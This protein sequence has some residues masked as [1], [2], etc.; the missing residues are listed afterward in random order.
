MGDERLQAEVCE[1]LVE[2][3]FGAEHEMARHPEVSGEEA[4]EHLFAVEVVPHAGLL[5]NGVAQKLED[6]SSFS[7]DGHAPQQAG[8]GQHIHGQY[9]DIVVGVSQM[10]VEQPPHCLVGNG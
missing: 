6:G 8:E 2:F 4:V 5:G 9:P 7:V 3:R 1:A 10:S